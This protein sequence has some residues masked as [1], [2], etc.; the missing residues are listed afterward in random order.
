MF[1]EYILCYYSILL[2]MAA[3]TNTSS[4]FHL[5]FL[6]SLEGGSVILVVVCYDPLIIYCCFITI[7]FLLVMC[8][9]LNTYHINFL[10]ASSL[11]VLEGIAIG[12]DRGYKVLGNTYP[13]IARKVLTDSSPKLRSSLQDLLYKVYYPQDINHFLRVI[14]Q[15]IKS[16]Y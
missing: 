4:G 8:N 11:A 3:G 16:R 12:I 10:S 9:Q 13:W 15:L 1:L 7:I 6:S 5:I 14:T 2:F